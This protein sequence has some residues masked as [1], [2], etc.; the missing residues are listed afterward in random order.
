MVG[1]NIKRYR[2][3]KNITQEALAETL[4]VTRQAVSNWECGK[5]EPDIETLQRIATVLDVTV[6]ELIYG[7]HRRAEVVVTHETKKVVRSGISLG[8]VL[9]TV[10]SYVEWQS[11]GWAVLHGVFGWGYVI[12]YIIRYGWS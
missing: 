11:I 10:I 6:E 9:A 3:E 5:A 2:E 1:K 8:A 4:C 12:Y 7:E